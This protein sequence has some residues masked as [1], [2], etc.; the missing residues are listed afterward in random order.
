M[1]FYT[2]SMNN[3]RDTPKL[4]GATMSSNNEGVSWKGLS[5]APRVGVG[6]LTD[7]R[8]LDFASP[9]PHGITQMYGADLS[10]AFGKKRESNGRARTGELSFL[11]YWGRSGDKFDQNDLPFKNDFIQFS[12]RRE[13]THHFMLT[14]WRWP[15]YAPV[16]TSN[17]WTFI[18][19]EFSTGGGAIYT[20]AKITEGDH[21]PR[22][23][24]HLAFVVTGSTEVRLFD[25]SY[26]HFQVSLGGAFRAF[27]G[28][29]FGLMGETDL[30]FA[31]NFF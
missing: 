15:T 2:T 14:E 8:F 31:Y 17:H 3:P 6:F 1:K 21:S 13:A 27:A 23:V 25:F 18:R 5:L 7:T 9:Y 19:P 24:T 30:R 28:E 12:L 20:Q 16:F 4:K 11:Y 10:I 22:E 29:A 26:E